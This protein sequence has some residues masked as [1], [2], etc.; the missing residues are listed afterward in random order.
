MPPS[1]YASTTSSTQHFLKSLHILREMF[2][3][4]KMTEPKHYE[5]PYDALNKYFQTQRPSTEFNENLITLDFDS[6]RM[7]YNLDDRWDPWSITNKFKTPILEGVEKRDVPLERVICILSHPHSKNGASEH[8]SS[9][10]SKSTKSFVTEL[11]LELEI[12]HISEL[13][14]NVTKHSLVP[15]HQIVMDKD[16][17]EKVK[18]DYQ[19][20]D[21]KMLPLI[22]NSDPVIRFIG[23]KTG[24]LIRITR[25]PNH[26]GEHILYRYCIG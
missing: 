3:Y 21:F 11:G 20:Q 17:R 10:K 1:T 9:N 13:Q 15:L 12:F 18:K 26:V 23:G 22:F 2:E 25:N 14:F 19:V 5:K 6:I 16:E 4:R 24:D 7:I 8:M